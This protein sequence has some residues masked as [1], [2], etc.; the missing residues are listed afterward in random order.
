MGKY[1]D[2]SIADS[3]VRLKSVLL[4]LDTSI[5]NGVKVTL[6]CIGTPTHYRL[7]ESEDLSSLPWLE[8]TEDII[9]PLTVSG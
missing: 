8:W 7:G 4:E 1:I 2:A 5:D 9:M 6:T 3:S